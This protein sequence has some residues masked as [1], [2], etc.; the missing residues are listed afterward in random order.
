MSAVFAGM[1]LC[2]KPLC[3][4]GKVN[5]LKKLSSIPVPL[6]SLLLQ[7]TAGYSTAE[8]CLIS[9][10]GVGTG[11]LTGVDAEDQP[12]SGHMCEGGLSMWHWGLA[13]EL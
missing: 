4:S 1:Q 5:L 11:N 7:A 10:T 3:C 9:V 8:S 6:A 12:L 2:S 13:I